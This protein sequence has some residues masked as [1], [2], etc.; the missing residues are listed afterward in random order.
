MGF[1]TKWEIQFAQNQSFD[2]AQQ[3]QQY[4]YSRTCH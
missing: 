3:Q 1:H 2:I 4:Y